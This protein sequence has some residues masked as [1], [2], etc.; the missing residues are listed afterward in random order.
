MKGFSIR[1][2]DVPV[3]MEKMH[4]H[5][6]FQECIHTYTGGRTVSFWFKLAT[7]ISVNSKFASLSVVIGDG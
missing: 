4:L 3:E 1:T 6:C 5:L 7:V 2:L